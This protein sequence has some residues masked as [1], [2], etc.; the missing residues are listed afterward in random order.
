M[1]TVEV[2]YAEKDKR[3]QK[4]VSLHLENGAT[5][6][7]AIRLSGLLELFPQINLARNAVGI[8]GKTVPLDRVVKDGDR[9]EIYRP[10]E[11]TPVERR[12][13]R[14]RTGT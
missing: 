9:I 4:I 2:A 3:L 8:Y 1:N 12:R 10:L 6:E 7:S 13:R 11:Q 14:A 5:V